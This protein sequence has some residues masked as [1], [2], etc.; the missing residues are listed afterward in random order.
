MV[1]C[2]LLVKWVMLQ[3]DTAWIREQSTRAVSRTVGH[4]VDLGAVAAGIAGS[5][6]VSSHQP[7]CGPVGGLFL[8]L[9]PGDVAAEG[10]LEA[11]GGAD[12]AVGVSIGV[13]EG[14]D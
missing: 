2:L 10:V 6:D 14:A 9:N 12:A 13:L 5:S 1:S 3:H 4:D 7:E 8:E 11:A